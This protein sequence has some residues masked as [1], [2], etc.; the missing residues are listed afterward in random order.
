MYQNVEDLIKLMRQYQTTDKNNLNK[1]IL[2]REEQQD[3]EKMKVLM[4]NQNW[5]NVY[6]QATDEIKTKNDHRKH[7]YYEQYMSLTNDRGIK[8]MTEENT[9]AFMQKWCAEQRKPFVTFM[10][11]IYATLAMIHPKR[12]TLYL[13]G[14]SNSGKTFVLREYFPSKT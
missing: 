4:R 8:M 13:Q 10:M 2:D 7:N 5:H 14:V 11:E 6:Q 12:N 9:S 3:S 1:L